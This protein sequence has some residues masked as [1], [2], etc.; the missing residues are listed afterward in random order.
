VRLLRCFKQRHDQAPM[1]AG[2]HLTLY[3]AGHKMADFFAPQSFIFVSHAW[4]D[5]T[6]KFVSHLKE[7]IEEQT[8][9]NVWVDLLGIDQVLPSS[10]A[11]QLQLACN[12][13]FVLTSVSR[14]A[15]RTWTTWCGG[16]EMR[17]APPA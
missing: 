12:C 8:L 6:A 11:V 17:C 3:A 2:S 9:L 15:R 13:V 16:S 5:G 1:S 14:C 4:G 10:S 7:T